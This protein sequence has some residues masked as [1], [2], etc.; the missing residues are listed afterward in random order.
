MP[1]KFRCE[2]DHGGWR[3]DGC[4]GR[5]FPPPRPSRV[6]LNHQSCCFNAKT[7]TGANRAFPP[8]GQ[9]CNISVGY[10]TA[11]G[12]N[13]FVLSIENLMQNTVLKR[14]TLGNN[15]LKRNEICKLQ[16]LLGSSPHQKTSTT[17]RIS[18]RSN[19]CCGEVS[20]KGS[21]DVFPGNKAVF[22]LRVEVCE[23]TRV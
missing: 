11:L 3:C 9:T 20:S 13:V 14:S 1:S 6:L 12:K 23:A 2:P 18:N 19:G 8:W 22:G 5:D 7:L 15:V 10:S 16:C 4:W 21:R 17:P